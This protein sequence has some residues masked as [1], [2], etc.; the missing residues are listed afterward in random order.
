LNLRESV[1]GVVLRPKEGKW[2]H[3]AAI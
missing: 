2:V 1:Y 3:R